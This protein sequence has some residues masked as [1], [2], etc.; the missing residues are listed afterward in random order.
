MDRVDSDSLIW[1]N[2][3]NLSWLMCLLRPAALPLAE[4][5]AARALFLAGNPNCPGNCGHLA[6]GKGIGGVE[7]AG[8]NELIISTTSNSLT[9]N[10]IF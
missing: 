9:K 5:V 7:R 4:K 8:P 3:L 1:I 6:V 2:F 10:Y